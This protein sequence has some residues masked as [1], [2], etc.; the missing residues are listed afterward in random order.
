MSVMAFIGQ[1][2]GAKRMDRVKQ[3]IID[4]MILVV[5]MQFLS[6]L[7]FTIFAHGL[8]GIIA[9]SEEVIQMAM[10]RLSVLCSCYFLCGIMEV[11]ANSCRAMGKP[12]FALF[13]SIMGATVFRIV[14]LKITF[15][16][17]PEFYIIF[18][19][20]PVSWVFTILC[21][22][23]VVPITFKQTKQRINGKTIKAQD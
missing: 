22:A 20:Y 7:A 8:C 15:A 18:L 1:N 19:S 2:I 13:V 3:V 6:G 11:L 12:I 10:I 5:L 17:V 9:N 14:F 21:Y 16:L 4:G 23:V